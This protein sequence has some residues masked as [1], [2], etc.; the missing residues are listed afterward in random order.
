MKKIFTLLSLCLIAMTSFAQEW[1][2]EPVS[3]HQYYITVGKDKVGFITANEDGGKLTAK[4]ASEENKAKQLWT[5]TKGE[6]D[7]WTFTISVDGGTWT[8]YTKEDRLFAGTDEQ[9]G[10][11][12]KAF[13]L[14]NH[15]DDPE[16][17]YASLKMKESDDNKNYANIFG[18]QKLGNEYGP[19]L[20]DDNGSKVYFAE[21][22]EVVIPTWNFAFNIFAAGDNSTRYFIQF[23]NPAKDPKENGPAKLEGLTAEH[24]VL[25]VDKDTIIADAIYDN[26]TNFK[27]KVWNIKKFDAENNQITLVNEAGQYIQY[28]NFDEPL[29]GGNKVFTKPEGENTEW[30]RTHQSGGGKMTGGFMATTEEQ[31]LYIFPSSQGAELYSI[32]DSS[33]KG[34]QNFLNAW[35][36]VAWHHFMG[37]W[38][39]DD[40]NN[41]LKFVPITDVLTSEQI[42]KLDAQYATGISNVKVQEKQAN[43][44]VYT[45]DGRV[46][47]KSLNGLA[48]G[49]Y[50]VNGKKVVVK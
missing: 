26:D 28:K 14:E 15:N 10:E 5:C 18:G 36:D 6:N 38:K 30:V 9:V 2:T 47:A 4:A 42:A 45:L 11:N 22:S 41:A 29:N 25:G 46:V 49:L 44:Y 17:V 3:G 37:K 16:N 23:N 40:K 27:Q 33:D 34:S 50:I 39:V 35:G 21:P 8:M 32:G 31:V 19:W 1:K 48:K 24:L 13:A 12:K 20:S 43:G 7:V